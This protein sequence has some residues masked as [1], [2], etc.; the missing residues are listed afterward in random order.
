MECGAVSE[1]LLAGRTPPSRVEPS[2]AF[3]VGFALNW[4]VLG[5]LMPKQFIWRGGWMWCGGSCMKFL[6]DTPCAPALLACCA[7][8][9]RSHV[10]YSILSSGVGGWELLVLVLP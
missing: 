1:L 2:H 8:A 7:N 3:K 5:D 9:R 6:A 4:R 10:I